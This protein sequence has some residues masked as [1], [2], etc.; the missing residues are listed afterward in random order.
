MAF[1]FNLGVI[2]KAVILTT[3]NTFSSD[4]FINEI[5]GITTNSFLI[6]DEVHHV[7][8]QSFRLGLL[9]DYSYR[10]GLSA[11]PRI[12]NNQEATKLLF[13]YFHG[14][15]FSYGLEIALTP[16]ETGDSILAPYDYFPKKVE[17]N[18]EELTEY[19]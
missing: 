3:H 4:F 19:M 15:V 1:D 2:E 8:S 5:L 14:I 18:E 17:L 7:A 12:Y 10:L 9:D 13:D 16:T 11:T 6:V